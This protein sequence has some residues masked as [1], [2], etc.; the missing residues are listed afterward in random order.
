MKYTNKT[1]L[2]AL[3]L[4]CGAANAAADAA[5]ELAN[6]TAANVAIVSSALAEHQKM[7]NAIATTRAENILSVLKIAAKGQQAAEREVAILKQTGGDDI[8][9]M[10]DAL[11]DLGERAAAIST[12]TDA[13]NAAAMADITASYTPLAI[14]TEKLDRAAKMLATLAKQQTDEDRAKNLLK[15]LKDTRDEAKALQEAS[16]TDKV[17]ADKKLNETTTKAASKMAASGNK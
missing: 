14:S 4:L 10:F 5:V 9:K 15:F 3:F 1:L 6:K 17:N 2:I 8:V 16:N 11:C 7:F 13:A 12:Q